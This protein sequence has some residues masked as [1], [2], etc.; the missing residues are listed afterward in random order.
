M[1]HRALSAYQVTI[2]ACIDAF[3]HRRSLRVT[4]V[5][6]QALEQR[7]L[8]LLDALVLLFVP[9]G[10]CERTAGPTEAVAAEMGGALKHTYGWFTWSPHLDSCSPIRSQGCGCTSYSSSGS[11]LRPLILALQASMMGEVTAGVRWARATTTSSHHPNGGGKYHSP[12]TAYSIRLR[13]PAPG[14]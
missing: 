13:F 2:N 1:P 11:G 7:A 6:I 10:V 9:P 4:P 5:R 8:G 14:T 12:A 3:Q